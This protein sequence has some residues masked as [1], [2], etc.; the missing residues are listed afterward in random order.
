[1]LLLDLQ[2]EFLLKLFL[3]F[4]YIAT[5]LFQNL[6]PS[7]TYECFYKSLE[8]KLAARKS[9]FS[10]PT[11]FSELS[12]L[13]H[14]HY[15]Q[16]QPPLLLKVR[17]KTHLI[18]KFLELK[19]ILKV[20]IVVS[21]WIFTFYWNCNYLLVSLSKWLFAVSIYSCWTVFV[22]LLDCVACFYASLLMLA[23]PFRWMS[24]INNH[25]SLQLSIYN[26][27]RRR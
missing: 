11:L 26:T 9:P 24:Q 12:S 20:R 8:I 17:Y 3:A 13:E 5:L 14:P 1:M 15:Q 25:I 27:K 21:V 23:G 22:E 6:W 2:V 7:F 10:W 4:K 16:R 19:A 18:Y